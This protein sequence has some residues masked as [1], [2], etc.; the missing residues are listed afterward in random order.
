MRTSVVN[1]VNSLRTVQN[2]PQWQIPESATIPTTT[3]A[4]IV[5]SLLGVLRAACTQGSLC[6]AFMAE[7]INSVLLNSWRVIELANSM[8]RLV[9]Y[10]LRATNSIWAVVL[11]YPR[12]MSMC[13]WLW[14]AFMARV[15]K[16][17]YSNDCFVMNQIKS[18]V[19]DAARHQ[20]HKN[21]TTINSDNTNVFRMTHAPSSKFD[22]DGGLI[23]TRIKTDQLTFTSRCQDFRYIRKCIQKTVLDSQSQLLLSQQNPL[24]SYFEASAKLDELAEAQSIFYTW[25]EYLDTQEV[26]FQYDVRPDLNSTADVKYNNSR[27]DSYVVRDYIIRRLNAGFTLQ[28]AIDL[29]VPRYEVVVHE[30]VLRTSSELCMNNS[31][32][33]TINPCTP[34]ENTYIAVKTAIQNSSS[35]NLP[36]NA[37][38]Q[39]QF[40]QFDTVDL[41][42]HLYRYQCSELRFQRL[43]FH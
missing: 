43:D 42:M 32:I 36:R 25:V 5:N 13:F 4:N 33:R 8:L 6:W 22:K 16:N 37:V 7:H 28:G 14:V 35:V 40:L 39:L 29:L 24:T 41:M 2:L 30:R 17:K 34:E 38:Q 1:L 15:L 9:T 12:A 31:T 21:I 10:Y 27:I 23:D 11:N 20:D 18:L 19:N 3:F 26:S